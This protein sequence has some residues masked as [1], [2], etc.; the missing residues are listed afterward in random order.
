MQDRYD[1]LS[2]LRQLLDEGTISQY[3]FEQEKARLLGEIGQAGGDPSFRPWGLELNTYCMLLHLSQLTNF[4]VPGLGLVL[5]IVMWAMNK[6]QS[7]LIDRHGKVVLN[8]TISSLIYVIIS[9]ALIFVLIGF[10]ML[11]ALGVMHL[12]FIVL[13]AVK[14]NEGRVWKYPLSIPFFTV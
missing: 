6:D 8:W 11:A 3:E 5:P 10:A 7:E 12:I 14:A 9:S 4:A 13:G 1:E 2:K